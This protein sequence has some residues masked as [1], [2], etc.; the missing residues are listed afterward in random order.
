MDTV[1]SQRKE[2]NPEN[3][4]PEIEIER[5]RERETDPLSSSLWVTALQQT[6]TLT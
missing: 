6:T 2:S 1:K 3:F 4:N 5:D